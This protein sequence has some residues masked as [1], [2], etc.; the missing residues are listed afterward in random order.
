MDD[1]TIKEFVDKWIDL[2]KYGEDACFKK[3][4]YTKF[5]ERWIRFKARESHWRTKKNLMKWY[6]WFFTTYLP[7]EFFPDGYDPYTDFK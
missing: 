3:L 1:K 5:W 4:G 6:E 7:N 2:H